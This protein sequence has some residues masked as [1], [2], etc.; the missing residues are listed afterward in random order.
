M[1]VFCSGTSNRQWDFNCS[2]SYPFQLKQHC[3]ILC[4]PLILQ[5]TCFICGLETK[6]VL[7]HF[8]VRCISKLNQNCGSL[9]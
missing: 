8:A 6:V 7:I 9:F 3:Y 4:L 2:H 5:Y 1:Y